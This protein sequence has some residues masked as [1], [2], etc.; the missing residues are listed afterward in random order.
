VTRFRGFYTSETR[1]LSIAASDRTTVLDVLSSDSVM[2]EKAALRIDRSGSAL[3]NITSLPWQTLV[4]REDGIRELPGAITVQRASGNVDVVNH[5]GKALKDALVWVPGDRVYYFAEIKDGATIHAKD[6][7]TALGTPTAT[8]SHAGTMAIHGLGDD[9]L[10]ATTGLAKRDV[11]RL[12]RDWAPIRAAAGDAVDWWPDDTP[13]VMGELD[14]GE[15]AASD[16]ALR[17]E[18]DRAL[19]RVVGKAGAP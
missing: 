5:S 11:E 19:V 17:V 16:G 12:Q 7:Q 10:S 6:G 2:G 15:G 14:G 9:E 18:S 4:V 13:V 8:G 1:A 3:E